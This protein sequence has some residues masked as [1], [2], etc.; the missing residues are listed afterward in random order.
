M[1]YIPYCA[2]R[3]TYHVSAYLVLSCVPL[4]L[5]GTIDVTF[6]HFMWLPVLD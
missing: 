5:A 1:K 3:L 6:S 4:S 2:A